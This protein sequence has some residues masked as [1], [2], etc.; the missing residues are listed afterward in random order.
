MKINKIVA[1]F[2][3]ST[4]A[5]VS[6]G[7]LMAY[8]DES[9]VKAE[10]VFPK[11]NELDVNGSV[12]IN[13]PENSSSDVKIDIADS[14]E[15]AYEYYSGTYAYSDGAS[16]S[17]DIEGNEDR[18]YTLDIIVSDVLNN[19]SS[20]IFTQD[21][22][23]EDAE[24]NPDSWTNY[25]YNITIEQKN[26]DIPFVSET[27]ETNVTGGKNI[28]TNITFYVS[29]L[30]LKGDVNNDC[31]IDAVD[32]SMVLSQYAAAATGRPGSFNESQ[33]RAGDV[34]EDNIID[35]VDASKILAYYA[36]IATGKTPSW[37]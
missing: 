11:F 22:I 6:T 10:P 17:F 9:A 29:E 19:L 24:Y 7:S 5:A 12:I 35:A 36:A 26:S 3:M 16:Y 14:P 8:A 20:Q 27:T 34:N 2:I 4:L 25:I 23:I 31:I 21:I 15:G 30:Y 32:A 13:L 37:D 18:V 28:E 1:A 33:I